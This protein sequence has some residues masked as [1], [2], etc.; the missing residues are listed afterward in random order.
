MEKLLQNLQTELNRHNAKFRI[1]SAAHISELKEEIHGLRLKGKISEEIYA[2]YLSKLQ[3]EA[4][5]ELP[6]AN[7]IVVIA[8]PQGVSI[9]TF[10]QGGKN[11][12]VIIPPTY[13]WAE[14]RDNCRSVL[15]NVFGET[16]A[17]ITRALL[18]LKLIATRSGLGKYGRN[19]ICYVEGMGS[20]A[21]LEAFYT[22]YPFGIDNWQKAEM[23]E[24]CAKC[25]SC[26]KNCPTQAIMNEESIINAK[27]CLTYLNEDNRNFP[28][29]LNVSSHNA[30]VGCMKCQNKCPENQP[31]IG[32]IYKNEEFSAE[33]TEVI[34]SGT[35]E[36]A[37]PYTLSNK[38]KQLSMEEY[39]SLLSRNLRVLLR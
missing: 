20:F 8:I 11:F 5:E 3:F 7:S 2:A 10:K 13:I 17:K 32:T 15:E 38:I 39:Y 31:F 29:W 21:R 30:L 33:E 9:L 1:I 19:N 14:A 23:L 26:I 6:G 25:K 28:Q 22:D 4:P 37:I 34:L 24:T 35:P 18:P 27:R 36:E 16:G 12:D